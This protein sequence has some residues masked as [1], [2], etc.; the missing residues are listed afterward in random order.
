MT[1]IRLGLVFADW[2]LR[3]NSV[4]EIRDAL[5]LSSPKMLCTV[6]TFYKLRRKTLPKDILTDFE[7][8]QNERGR[9]NQKRAEI[10]ANKGEN[11]AAL[12]EKYVTAQ[13]PKALTPVLPSKSYDD[14]EDLRKLTSAE[15]DEE[16]RRQRLEIIQ[17]NLKLLRTAI[18]ELYYGTPSSHNNM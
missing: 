13:K 10:D 3:I 2:D 6:P 8:Q 5:R 16:I 7:E 9:I 1:C 15:K 4:D 11:T 14:G 12:I 17:D 18:P